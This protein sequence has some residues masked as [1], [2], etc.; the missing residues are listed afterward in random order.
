[1][2]SVSGTITKVAW[3]HDGAPGVR[4]LG[5]FDCPCG[6]QVRDVEYGGAEMN[7]C[8]SCGARYDGHGWK[9]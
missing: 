8:P 5:H 2:M 9:I 7:T 3:I 1:M 4:S 6:D